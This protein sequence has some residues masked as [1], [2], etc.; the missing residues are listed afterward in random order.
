[1]KPK[2]GSITG[3]VLR[4]ARLESGRGH[5][6][7]FS[8]SCGVQLGSF[9]VSR[10]KRACITDRFHM[11][12]NIESNQKAHVSLVTQGGIWRTYGMFQLPEIIPSKETQLGVMRVLKELTDR[13]R[14]PSD[15]PLPP[16]AHP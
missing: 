1:M 14:V 7:F 5:R 11:L 9:T 8:C 15:E 16:E 13:C 10:F 6:L 3:H 12:L 4:V 2:P